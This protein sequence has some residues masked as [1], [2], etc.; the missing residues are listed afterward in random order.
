MIFG[1]N[2]DV[3]HGDTVYHVQSEAREREL[4]LQTQVFVTGRCIGKRAS[5]YADRFAQPEFSSEQMHDLLREQHRDVVERIR[6][7]EVGMLF[8][9]AMR[10]E[11]GI[12]LEWLNPDAVLSG[13]TGG[14]A[15]FVLKVNRAGQGLGG[16][17][18]MLRVE[19]PESHTRYGQAMTDEAGEA[20]VKLSI[21][22]TLTAKHDRIDVL[23][24]AS[25]A[26]QLATRKYR[27]RKSADDEDR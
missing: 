16:A 9:P 22:N 24:Q 1:F 26:G 17:R 13:D 15:A 23:L 27:L 18:V 21:Q 20:R 2:T 5:S 4:L 7:G 10:S 6:S 14:I 25:H 12:S 3:K 19:M 8:A 11:E